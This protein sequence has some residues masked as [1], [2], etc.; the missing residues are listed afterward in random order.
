MG[1]KETVMIRDESFSLVGDSLLPAA[2]DEWPAGVHDTWPSGVHRLWDH[3]WANTPQHQAGQKYR[4]VIPGTQERIHLSVI[5][6][7]TRIM[8]M[9]SFS[10]SSSTRLESQSGWLSS[11]TITAS[12]VSDFKAACV[13]V[14]YQTH[15]QP[16]MSTH[17][18]WTANRKCWRRVC[19]WAW[20]TGTSSYPV[21]PL[22]LSTLKRWLKGRKDLSRRWREMLR[23]VWRWV[24]SLIKEDKTCWRNKSYY[25]LLL[26]LSLKLVNN[27]KYY[28]DLFY[29]GPIYHRKFLQLKRW[30]EGCLSKSNT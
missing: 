29:I 22:Y 30:A 19:C 10:L 7:D 18:W 3:S 12:Q 1:K 25:L 20:G 15:R 5:H 21:S 14:D 9:I 28:H 26:H 2:S 23:R 16:Q 6:H 13:I 27:E 24:N 8:L 4:R 11:Q 17:C